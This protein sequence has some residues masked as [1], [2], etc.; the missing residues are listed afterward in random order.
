MSAVNCDIFQNVVHKHERGMSFDVVIRV[1]RARDISLRRCGW[2]CGAPREYVRKEMRNSPVGRMVS[3]KSDCARAR[4]LLMR[5]AK[6]RQRVEA[7]RAPARV[8]RRSNAP[9]ATRRQWFSR[10]FTHAAVLFVVWSTGSPSYYTLSKKRFLSFN[11]QDFDFSFFF[12][13]VM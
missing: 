10:T 2:S 11:G 1:H 3:G 6:Q 8:P 9:P 4:A 13:F 5:R 7:H 12:D